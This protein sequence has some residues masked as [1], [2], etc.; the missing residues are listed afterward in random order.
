MEEREN[1]EGMFHVQVLDAAFEALSAA[2]Q[3]R[4]LGEF[5]EHWITLIRRHLWKV[6]FE[7]GE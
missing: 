3:Y 6:T 1:F 2:E 7:R 4:L 5:K